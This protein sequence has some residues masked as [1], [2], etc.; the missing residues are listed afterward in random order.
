MADTAS[1]I[2][3]EP[4]HSWVPA[5]GET[6]PDTAVNWVCRY[7]GAANVDHSSGVQNPPRT[8]A[9]ASAGYHFAEDLTS[10]GSLKTEDS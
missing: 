5:S 2:P 4:R 9:A 6:N 10:D 8:W 3:T 7:C 1:C